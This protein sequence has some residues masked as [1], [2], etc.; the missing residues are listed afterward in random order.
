MPQMGMGL[1]GN[2]G[3]LDFHESG[4]SA[5]TVFDTGLFYI[6]LLGLGRN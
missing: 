4:I 1:E 3:L 5:T 6:E 2:V